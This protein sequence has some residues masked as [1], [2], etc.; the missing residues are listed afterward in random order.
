M[1]G[2][3]HIRPG[4]NIVINGIDVQRCVEAAIIIAQSIA[5]GGRYYGD[6]DE[7]HVA[8][9]GG[10]LL[11]EL[12]RKGYSRDICRDALWAKIIDEAQR[13]KA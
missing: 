10:K 8:A 7:H 13:V 4:Q 5:G 6:G 9:A 11:A 1:T 12:K 2:G 3:V